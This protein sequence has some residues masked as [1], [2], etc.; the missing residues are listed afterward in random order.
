[1]IRPEQTHQLTR[2]ESN[3]DQAAAKPAACKR[4]L[5]AQILLRIADM[6]ISS[7]VHSKS[8]FMRH[9]QVCVRP[10]PSAVNVTLPAFD[11]EC[12][13]LLHG[14]RSPPAAIGRYLLFEGRSAANPPAPLLLSIANNTA[15]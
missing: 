5:L 9:Q 13:R 10:P 15:L 2:T 1:L 3:A 11:T 8:T 7:T 6:I 4:S 12:R 14:A